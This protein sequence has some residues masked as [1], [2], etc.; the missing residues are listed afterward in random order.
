MTYLYELLSSADLSPH[1]ICLL[2]RP[3]LVWLHVVS[4]GV[5]GLAYYSIPLAL[6]YFVWHRRDVVFGWVFWMFAGFILA[7]GTTHLLSIWTLWHPDYGAE[8]LV[9]AFTALISIGTAA[10]LWPLLPK[11]L[12]LPAPAALQRLNDELR[13]KVDERDRAFRQLSESEQRFRA[14]FDNVPERLFV[15]DVGAD[16][17]FR[18]AQFNP[19]AERMGGVANSEARGK[20][21]TELVPHLAD[22]LIAHYR[23]CV[24][25]AGPV[26][27]EQTIDFRA[28]ERSW[29]TIL[30]P[31]SDAHGRI[32]TIVGSGRD[33][34]ERRES[35]LRLRQAQKMEAIGQLTGGIAHDFNNLLTVVMGNLEVI[36][37]NV[38]GEPLLDERIELA[39]G[40]V[41]RGARLTRQLLAFARRQPLDSRS[42]DLGGL[43]GET[44][45]LLRKT[46]GARIAIETARADDLWHALV[47][48]TQVESAV[49]NLALNACDAMP[50]GGKLKIALT[51]AVLTAAAAATNDEVA[52][53]EYVL[54]TVSDNGTGMAPTVL[55]KAFD[56][57]FTTKPDGQG[58]GLCLSMVYGFAKQ[59]GGHVQIASTPGA[60]T[61]VRLYLPRTADAATAVGTAAGIRDAEGRGTI[62]VVEDDHA[63]RDAVV[64]MLRGLGYAVLAADGPAD[65]LAILQARRAVDLLFT[66]VV[67]PGPITAR[68]LVRQARAVV[69]RLKVLFTSGHTQ[70]TIVPDGRLEAGVALLNKPYRQ[71]ELA[72]RI[73]SALAG[74]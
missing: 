60:G 31:V 71:T 46:L 38:A 4:D 35:E 15:I 52:P 30:V 19:A 40:G 2:W 25:A 13:Q 65:A 28:G 55:E 73:T 32:T 11:A 22:T 3:E 57:F 64:G 23:D 6:A 41:E 59:S 20:T 7:C 18:Y 49:I 74:E 72:A 34:T 37:R 48:P 1:G 5:I 36:R 53:G 54:I 44:V 16:G 56:P 70:D 29:E 33:V 63:V 58:T 66:D 10:A 51:N 45:D 17:T 50:D 43:I 21:P 8:G 39:I 42:V 61:A 67:M 62:L 68:E 14:Y 27:Y 9:K 12:A 47:D 69:P 24:A 26:R